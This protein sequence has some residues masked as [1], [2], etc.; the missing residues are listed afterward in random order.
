MK[1][2]H[3]SISTP[4]YHYQVEGDVVGVKDIEKGLSVLEIQGHVASVYGD[5]IDKALD[6]LEDV[7]KILD[8]VK[9]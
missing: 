8:W 4:K 1:L 6:M 5:S 2:N 7:E 9:E 3:I